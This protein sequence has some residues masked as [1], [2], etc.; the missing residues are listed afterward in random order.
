M[1][2]KR[3]LSLFPQEDPSAMA[4]LWELIE[5]AFRGR[6]VVSEN[7][8][9]PDVWMKLEGIPG[10]LPPGGGFHPFMTGDR[11]LF[12]SPL[13]LAETK[14]RVLQVKNQYPQRPLSHRDYLGALMNLGIRREKFGDL[15]VVGDTCFIPMTGTLLSFVK[16]H[17]TKV[18]N[19]GVT[20]TERDP[21]QLQG[22]QRSFEEMTLLAAS[23]RLDVLTAEITD[24]SRSK[25][26]ELIRSGRVQ[27]NY[28][29][30]RDRSE[31]LKAG[32]I[33]TIRGHGKYRIGEVQGETRKGRLRLFVE[34][35]S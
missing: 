6:P 27:V 34:K 26:E 16:E 31:L 10:A 12:A 33:L 1:D 21:A 9:P 8:Y 14:I 35:Y 18:G 19:N 3:F 23:L 25:A 5:G 13:A 32:D 22:F 28:T 20:L 4:A 7:F 17:L 24:L 29:E 11:R 15:F 2:K 30:T